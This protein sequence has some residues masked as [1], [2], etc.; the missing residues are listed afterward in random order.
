MAVNFFD[1]AKGFTVYLPDSSKRLTGEGSGRFKLFGDQCP[2][3]SKKL[4][5][6]SAEKGQ[7]PPPKNRQ[8]IHPIA[9]LHAPANSGLAPG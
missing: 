1:D 2:L 3:S 5:N 7:V 6:H 9:G 4:I 8:P